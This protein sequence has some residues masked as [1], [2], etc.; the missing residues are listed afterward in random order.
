VFV[1]MV[2]LGACG[3]SGSPADPSAA[4][5]APTTEAMAQATVAVTA[6]DAD[7]S[8]SEPDPVRPTPLVGVGMTPRSYSADDFPV[9]LG[10]IEGRSDL[11][12][13]AGGWGDLTAPGSAFEVVVTLAREREMKSVVVLSPN[14]GGTLT[15]ALDEATV[16]SLLDSL[17][18]FLASNQPEYL[19]L[20][21]EVNMLATDDP[22]AFEAVVALWQ[23]ALPIVRELSPAT[24]VFVTFQYEWLV[25]RRD[26]WFGRTVVA[27]DWSPLDRFGDADLVGLTT[28]PSLVFD[29]PSEIPS[30]YYAQIGEHT[31][32]PLIF[33]EVGWTADASLA[34]L[35]GSD[36]EQVSYVEMLAEQAEAVAVEGLVWTF[37]HGEQVT[38]VP[39]AGMGL[40]AAD[41]VPRPAFDAWMARRG[42]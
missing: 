3:G 32:L 37:V 40:F 6:G 1:A 24:K 23:R 35:P 16:T 17:R 26:G 19:G 28:Y 20:A 41:G 31:T 27:T 30:D 18:S 15:T 39:F 7:P 14:S 2:G 4:T 13:H 42:G 8:T 34:L 10:E 21:N 36:A 9:F 12:M 25:G 38:D 29:T 22:A 33:T 5:T 11:L